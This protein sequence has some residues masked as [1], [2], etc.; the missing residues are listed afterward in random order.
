M[1]E[2]SLQGRVAVVT[3]GGSGIGQATCLALAADGARVMVAD[4]ILPSALT[5]VHRIQAAGGG[6]AAIQVDVAEPGDCKRMARVTREVLGGLD[7]LVNN[8]G[9]DLP[10]ATTVVD[11]TPA[12]WDRV[13][14]VNLKG[15]YL[16]CK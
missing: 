12:D 5:T 10:Q 14:A 1:P 7:I 3:G 8:A 6:A 9:I 11:T 4:L 15:V 13:F 2:L 16:G